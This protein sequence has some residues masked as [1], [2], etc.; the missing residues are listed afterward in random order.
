MSDEEKSPTSKSK[1]TKSSLK[2]TKITSSKKNNKKNSKKEDKESKKE[3]KNDTSSEEEESDSEEEDWSSSDSDDSRENRRSKKNRKKSKTKKRKD[4]RKAYTH[5][6]E[7]LAKFRTVLREELHEN[8]AGHQEPFSTALYKN[9]SSISGGHITKT[10]SGQLSIPTKKF[11]KHLQM[12]LNSKL[13]PGE[14]ERLSESDIKHLCDILDSNNDG[15]IDWDEFVSAMSYSNEEITRIIYK[16]R[17]EIKKKG[18]KSENEN[19]L[20]MVIGKE[21]NNEGMSRAV[22][23]RYI[24]QN[25]FV[26][27]SEGEL[28]EIFQFLDK[29]GNGSVSSKE[30]RK[31]INTSMHDLLAQSD[32]DDEAPIVDI[33]FTVGNSSKAVQQEENFIHLG[34]R[35]LN[36]DLNGSSKIAKKV[37]L[38]FLK[39]RAD[40]YTTKEDFKRD[41]ITDITISGNKR[42]SVLVSQGFH[43]IPQ[44]LNHGNSLLAGSDIYLWVRKNVNDS[45]P[46]LNVAVTMGKIKNPL[47]PI[48]S[49]P[50]HGYKRCPGMVN[51]GGLFFAKDVYLWYRKRSYETDVDK[52]D[53]ANAG[54]AHDMNQQIIDHVRTVLR[55]HCMEGF[56]KIDLEKGFK[57]HDTKK[58]G[59]LSLKEFRHVLEDEGI[60]L[61]QKEFDILFKKIDLKGTNSITLKDFFVFV[62]HGDEEIDAMAKKVRRKIQGFARRSKKGLQSVFD[63]YDRK[64]TGVINAIAFKSLLKEMKVA[65]SKAE[66]EKFKNRFDPDGSGVISKASF[67][68]FVYGNI[69][70]YDREIIQ[71]IYNHLYDK[72]ETIALGGSKSKKRKNWQ[73]AFDKLAF[74]G[75]AASHASDIDHSEMQRVQLDYAFEKLLDDSQER[76]LIGDEEMELICD[77]FD[78]KHDKKNK[79]ANEISFEDFKEGIGAKFEAPKTLKRNKMKVGKTRSDSRRVNRMFHLIALQVEK[80]LMQRDKD[81]SVKACFK[82]FDVSRNGYIEIDEFENGI[83]LLKLTKDIPDAMIQAL[84]NQ[85]DSKKKGSVT[86]SQFVKVMKGKETDNYQSGSDSASSDSDPEAEAG[87]GGDAYYSGSSD[88][89]YSPRKKTTKKKKKNRKKKD[90]YAFTDSDVDSSVGGYT[91]SDSSDRST[92]Y[93]SSPLSDD[94]IFEHKPKKIKRKKLKSKRKKKSND[95]KFWKMIR[96]KVRRAKK[97]EG[98]YGIDLYEIF[99]RASKKEQKKRGSKKIKKNVISKNG[100]HKVINS[101]GIDFSKSVLSKVQKN[102]VRGKNK[103]LVNYHLFLISAFKDYQD[104][105]ADDDTDEDD[106]SAR[107]LSGSQIREKLRR[108]IVRS[109]ESGID[110]MKM[111]QVFDKNGDK[112]LTADELRSTSVALGL[113]MSRRE[114]NALVR[115]L[116]RDGKHDGRVDYEELV[117]FIQENKK[118]IAIDEIENKIKDAIHSSNKDGK[119]LVLEEEFA[120]F[121]LNGD[122]YISTK[123]FRK[124]LKEAFDLTFSD[125]QYKALL[126]RVDKHGHGKID[127]EHFAK[128]YQYG[129]KDLEVLAVKLRKRFLDIAV[130]KAISFQEIF[131]SMDTNGDGVISRRE[132]RNALNRTSCN[133]TERELRSLMDKFD[134]KRAGRIYYKAFVK[135]A[136]PKDSDLS[137]IETVIRE[138]VRELARVRGGLKT[139]DMVAPFE[140]K[141]VNRNGQITIDEFKHALESLGLD[142]TQREFRI[143]CARF[144]DNGDGYINYKAFCRFAHL[145]DKETM[146]MCKRLKKRLKDAASEEIYVRDI[147]AK[148]DEFNKTGR[149]T[150]LQFR[151]GAR[152]LNLG[153]SADERLTIEDRFKAMDNNDDFM[154]LDFLKWVNNA[155]EDGSS[156]KA[157][158]HGEVG[159]DSNILNTTGQDD[160]VW[161][162]RTV[163]TWLNTQ[164]SPRQRRRFNRLYASLSSYKQNSRRGG[165]KYPRPG[166]LDGSVLLG[167]NNDIFASPRRG[168]SRLRDPKGDIMGSTVKKPRSYGGIS[169]PPSTPVGTRNFSSSMNSTWRGNDQ[170]LSSTLQSD[171][172]GSMMSR[173]QLSAIETGDVTE[174]EFRDN[175]AIFQQTGNWACPVCMFPNNKNFSRKCDMCAS[176]NP[177]MLPMG[178][179]TS[180]LKFS[181][182]GAQTGGGFSSPRNSSHIENA[183]DGTIA[184]RG[185]ESDDDRYAE[186]DEE[187]RRERKKKKKERKKYSD[188]DED[189]YDYNKKKKNRRGRSRNKFSD[190]DEDGSGYRSR[191][192]SKGRGKSSRRKKYTDDETDS[193]LDS[194]RTRSDRRR[195]RKQRY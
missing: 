156:R 170:F 92:T 111:F 82:F 20:R 169:M 27:L 108:V 68:K 94:E 147:F 146:A 131:R 45:F 118:D 18:N 158:W 99:E 61:E 102:F 184:W 76:D 134:S 132:F 137:D 64:K 35:R 154:Y 181:F 1:N 25:L 183:L 14:G 153:L 159:N 75:G 7:M 50:F 124:T 84:F 178:A 97:R 37:S 138:R 3:M 73:K 34:Y 110:V 60:L 179:S 66:M 129:K 56:G 157:A 55:E 90:A 189:D 143:V 72:L 31:F 175:R 133:L 152:Y 177:Y 30:L 89:G 86:Q 113:S 103:S 142:I 26:E 79:F 5:D 8:H 81:Y 53:L 160:E 151:E 80:H 125:S 15:S 148:H 29:D 11:G 46:L 24:E 57:R 126:K 114:A 105:H 71:D 40:Q 167:S 32:F 87:V 130:D 164:A 16:L 70:E 51:K 186:S 47:D 95:G 67:M 33:Q 107:S 136:S 172:G 121:D 188:E 19:F 65:V 109:K 13:R 195:R 155:N 39:K 83:G 176:A 62:Q 115:Y 12:V 4:L 48:H 171:M 54:N 182:T 23:G 42:D 161:N 106:V 104:L 77:H 150:K 185:D 180:P 88:D 38:W 122:G 139:L 194:P 193:G 100:F 98:R 190:D 135:F 120:R 41:R 117:D 93:S 123:E 192:R 168:S 166:N 128:R 21:A 144:D 149:V 74:I 36:A 69:A 28:R 165:H 191:S 44:S 58:K 140:R 119:P 63:K 96:H 141:D 145:D 10:K 6:E 174:Q 127:Y 49:P 173:L 43:C 2:K 59:A 9:F 91:S 17:S 116:D 112:L 187:D 78:P 52:N 101:V 162:S 22:L 85:L 163:R